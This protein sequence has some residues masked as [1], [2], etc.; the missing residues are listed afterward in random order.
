MAAATLLAGPVAAGGSQQGQPAVEINPGGGTE[1]DGSDGLRVVINA[2][3]GF[4]VA[5]G[6]EQ[7]FYQNTGQFTAGGSAPMLNIGGTLYGE[8]GAAYTTGTS[9]D[10]LEIVSTTGSTTTSA[11]TDEGSGSAHLRYTINHGGRAYVVDRTVSYVHPN[12]FVTEQYQFT[13]PAGNTEMVKYYLGG[14][15]APGNVDKGVGVMITEPVRAVYSVNPNTEIQ[16]VFS[17]APG[18]APFDGANAITYS[19]KYADI[20]AGGDIGFEIDANIHDAGIMVQ[21]TLGSEP[22]TYDRSLTQG[23]S[24]RG[25]SLTAALR[26]SSV[27]AGTPVLLDLSILNTG[28]SQETGLGYTFELPVGLEIAA[29]TPE[30]N[31]GGTLTGVVGSSTITLSGA[32]VTAAANCVSSIPVVA[33]NGGD[34]EITAAAVTNISS[35]MYNTVGASTVT[36]VGPTVAAETGFC[37][38]L[39]GWDVVADQVERLYQASLGRSAD[40]DGI[41]YWTQARL[42]GMSAR[43]LSTLLLG[44]EERLAQFADLSD[45]DFVDQLYVDILDRAADDEGR[46][47]WV[48]Q[49]GNGWTRGDI[50]L[51]FSDSVENADR[52]DTR[53]P[54]TDNEALTCRLYRT[55]LDRSP[56]DGGFG[57]WVG[58]LD[59]GQTPAQVA[60]AM[61]VTAEVQNLDLSDDA[62]FID[63]VYRN[64][65]LQRSADE[66]GRGFWSAQAEANGRGWVVSQVANALEQLVR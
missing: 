25:A 27:N 14:D 20:W 39:H 57:Y 47:H 10:S 42:S 1:T 56:G 12:N 38:G 48:A 66:G 50:V 21:W 65:A 64:G 2:D 55:V 31:C 7:L 61:L 43:E 63:H 23:V 3:I 9:W 62:D 54:M 33:G 53:A 46:A 58:L 44:S 5:S 49:L 36:V 13:I 34:Y 19:Q 6:S 40:D 15:S 37:P 60:A 11:G 4:G 22:G 17:E 30:N 29:G 32:S 45:E 52:T 41:L 18:S 26:D 24:R 59:N 8:A 51:F 16:I 28:S 35:S